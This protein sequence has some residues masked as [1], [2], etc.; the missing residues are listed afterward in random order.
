LVVKFTFQFL[1]FLDLSAGFHEILLQNVVSLSSDS[2]HA[3][4]CA[5]VSHV[6]TV[7]VFTDF[8]T[9]LIVDFSVLGNSLSVDLEDIEST[10]FVWQWN[11]DFP[12]KSSWSK[13]SWI[14]SIR[15]VGGHNGL[16]LTKIVETIKLIEELH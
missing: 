2:E 1:G 13:K 15:S 10:R 4:F 14:Q 12:I 9:G 11:L 6:S 5:D 8:G 7:K 16:N 3:C